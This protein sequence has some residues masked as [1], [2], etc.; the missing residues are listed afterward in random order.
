MSMKYLGSN[1]AKILSHPAIFRYLKTYS[2]SEND[3]HLGYNVQYTTK[4]SEN[5]QTKQNHFFCGC[6]FKV[7][8][9]SD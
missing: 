1:E 6:K 5:T 9:M 8:L 4:L 7:Y 2:M 3:K